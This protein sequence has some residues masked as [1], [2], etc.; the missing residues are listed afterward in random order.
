MSRT[1]SNHESNRIKSWVEQGRIMS[2][3]VSNHGSNHELNRV[4]RN[5]QGR[6]R[7]RT[8]WNH[9]SNRVES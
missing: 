8:G 2:R 6:I 1:G 3:T 5:E 9:E 4:E 7:R